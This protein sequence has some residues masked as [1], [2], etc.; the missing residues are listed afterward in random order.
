[1]KKRKDKIMTEPTKDEICL[2]CHL[3]SECSGCC[4][5]LCKNS[6]A[7]A[8]VCMQD[9]IEQESRL[10][11]WIHIIEDEENSRY[12]QLVKKFSKSKNR[13]NR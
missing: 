5:Y 11:A 9:A 3:S 7:S 10:D 12:K 6:C 4:H 1:M 2:M 13:L 8:Q